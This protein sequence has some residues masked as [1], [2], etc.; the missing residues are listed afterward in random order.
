MKTSFLQLGAGQRPRRAVSAQTFTESKHTGV[1]LPGHVPG[2]V[3]AS[4]RE[5]VHGFGWGTRR[6]RCFASS[7]SRCCLS[8]CS[9]SF[10]S[11]LLPKKDLRK[12]TT[13]PLQSHQQ[14]LSLFMLHL[15]FF[16]EKF[17]FKDF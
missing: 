5:R 6:H 2:S 13:G 4:C 8:S 10:C 15:F 12:Q 1:Y 16:T 7:S 14:I 17:H 9:F 3:C 11:S